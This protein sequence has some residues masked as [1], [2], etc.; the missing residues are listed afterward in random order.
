[1]FTKLYLET[2]DPKLSFSR[3]FGPRILGPMIFSVLLHT[4]VYALFF[5]MISWIFF[6]S[7]LSKVVNKRL[8][9]SLVLIMVFGFF[10]RFFH[11]KEIYEGYG[12]D[13]KK[14]RKYIDKHYISWVFIS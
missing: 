5:N 8:L 12:R 13:M 14:T 2:T 1:M 10:G 11:V 9:I 3:M 7:I 6:G 4:I